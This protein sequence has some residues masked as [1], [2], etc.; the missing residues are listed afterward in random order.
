[1]KIQVKRVYDKVDA[2]D[3]IRILVDRLWPRGLSKERAKIDS[4]IKE[5]APSNELRK[6]FNHEPDKWAEFK[7]RY[8]SELESNRELVK[9]IYLNMGDD[10]VTFLFSSNE[11]QFNNAHAL[12]EYFE[13]YF[14][15]D[16]NT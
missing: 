6:W 4:W 7:S 8:N 13:E 2:E 15:L 5:I 3:G 14:K 16:E 11:R 1:M 9:K 10:K 12:K